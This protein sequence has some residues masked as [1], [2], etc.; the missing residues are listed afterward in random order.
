M[1]IL[2]GHPTGNPNSHH[3]ALAHFEAGR[4]EAFCVPWMPSALALRCLAAMPGQAGLARRL[5]R[6]RFAPL[7]KAPKIQGRLG[8]FRRLWLRAR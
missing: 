2:F 7:E 8:E 3:A 4:L 6:R 5:S 1:S